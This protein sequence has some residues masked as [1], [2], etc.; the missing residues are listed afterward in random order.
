MLRRLDGL[1]VRLGADMQQIVADQLAVA[2]PPGGSNRRRDCRPRDDGAALDVKLL[3]SELPFLRR[4]AYQQLPYLRR[5]VADRRATILHRM[6]TRRV[7]FI[8]RQRRVGGNEMDRLG[9]YD[10]LLSGN[11]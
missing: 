2:G 11:L 10:Q 7:A 8:R 5:G 3:N 1:R 9:R 4:G 6:A